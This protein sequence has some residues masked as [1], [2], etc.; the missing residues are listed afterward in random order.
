MNSLEMLRGNRS[1]TAGITSAQSTFQGRRLA[2][3][4]DAAGVTRRVTRVNL[5]PV[6]VAE[7]VNDA[8]KRGK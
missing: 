7:V 5:A 2:K 3:A 6:A 1:A 8:E 4:S